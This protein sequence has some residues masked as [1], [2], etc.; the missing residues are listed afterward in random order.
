[1]YQK[2]QTPIKLPFPKLMKWLLYLVT[3]FLITVTVLGALAF[4]YSHIYAHRF[5]PGVKINNQS[6][7]KL[8]QGQAIRLIQEQIDNFME[9]GLIYNFQGEKIIIHPNLM[10]TADPDVSH[11]LISFNVTETVDRAYLIGRKKGYHKNFLEQMHVLILD[12][13]LPMTFEFNQQEFLKILENTLKPFTSTKKDAHPQID[14]KLNI[15][16]LPE[17]TGTT[18]NYQRILQETL[19]QISSLSIEPLLIN[20]ISD[21]PQIKKQDISQDLI[22]ELKKFLEKPVITLAAKKNEWP[23]TNQVF[24]DWLI[25]KKSD[26]NIS[27][28]FDASTTVN[29]LATNIAPKLY[30]PTLDAKFEIKNGRVIE[31]QGSQD[32]QSLNLVKSA[33]KM[34]RELLE[35]Q[36]NKV[37]LVVNLTRAKI[38]TASVN[39]LGVS[40]II[41]TGQSN[42]SGSPQN[43]RH[44]ISVGAKNLN[45]ILIKPGEEFSLINALGEVDSAAGYRPELVIK[46]DKT[47]PEYG[48]GLCQIGTTMFR[49]ALASGLPITERRNHSYRVVYYEPAGKDATIYNPRP[50][51]KFINDIGNYIL[52]QSR[53]EGDELYF[54]FWSKMDGRIIE[55]SDSVI[56]NIKSAGPTQYSETEELKPGEKKCT[57]KAHAGADAYFDYKVTYPDG[58]VKEERFTSHYIPWPA[59]CLVGKEPTETI[60]TSTEPTINQ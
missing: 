57:E 30:R 55:Q 8:N 43:R 34:E 32:G 52:I 14:E 60:P 6:L 58:N 50:D 7:A 20:L 26:K 11:T 51:L 45:G 35:N 4:A 22:I 46:G 41:G 49:A 37:E 36:Q 33:A 31:F 39:D 19:E 25:F 54:D 13:N 3:I 17:T 1:M 44:N 15:T 53:I 47:I 12:Y 10:A 56:Y 59:R 28:G 21:A 38:A 5:F 48:G 29:Y 42:F 24:K 18:F 9:Q 16:I 40:E 23:I 27:I 2:K